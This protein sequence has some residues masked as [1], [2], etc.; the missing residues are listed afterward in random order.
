MYWPNFGILVA[1]V[2][3]VSLDVS[4]FQKANKNKWGAILGCAIDVSEAVEYAL[5]A[6]VDTKKHLFFCKHM[7]ET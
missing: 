5:Q 4:G 3:P 7:I 2:P 6:N 1:R